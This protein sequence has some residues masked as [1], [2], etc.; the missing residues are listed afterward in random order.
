MLDDREIV[1]W[2]D[3][4]H[5]R[6][7]WIRV[8]SAAFVAFESMAKKYPDCEYRDLLLLA[9]KKHETELV[10]RLAYQV[11]TNPNMEIDI[12]V[13]KWLAILGEIVKAN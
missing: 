2:L 11:V 7:I 1:K 3:R 6:D 5:G 8:G 9:L 12:R 4:T 13:K 10:V